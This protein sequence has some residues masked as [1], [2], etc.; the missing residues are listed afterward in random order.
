MYKEEELRKDFSESLEPLIEDKIAQD[1]PDVIDFYMG[2]CCTITEEYVKS[3]ADDKLYSGIEDL[4]IRWSNDGTK[5]A[6]NLTRQ[7]I[8]LIKGEDE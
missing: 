8:T 3:L 2:V 7:I 1:D 4:V 6:G 5:T